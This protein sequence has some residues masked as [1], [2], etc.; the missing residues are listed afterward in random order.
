MDMSTFGMSP[1]F[2]GK[3][4][5]GADSIFKSDPFKQAASGLIQGGVGLFG[6]MNQQNPS[7]AAN[8]YFNQI[9]G[10]ISPYYQPYIDAGNQAIPQ[11]Q[12]QYGQ[13]TNDPGGKFNQ[14]GQ[15]FHQSPGY[16][17]AL[18]Q[19]LNGANN[20]AAAGGL[21]GTNAHQQ[22]SSQIAEGLANQ[23]YYNYMNGA[24]GLYGQGL[25]GLNNMYNGG[26]N[27]SN[28]LAQSLGNI[29]GAQGSNAYAGASNQ[30]SSDSDFFGGLGS[31]L[32]KGAL[33]AFL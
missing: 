23:D 13:L 6:N 1:N 25:G 2:N 22:Q 4:Y 14:I 10:T 5:G 32:G 12:S 24:L 9:P 17:F 27:A 16:Q 20:A 21:L 26:Y 11:L 15:S 30:N 3:P 7:Q 28:E 33:A 8:Q 29:L 19:G 18:Q 31:L